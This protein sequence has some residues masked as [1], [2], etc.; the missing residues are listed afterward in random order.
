L[1]AQI[2]QQF[3]RYCIIRQLGAGA[4]GS[5]YLARDTQLDRDVALKVPQFKEGR[6]PQI[7]ARFYQEARAAATIHHPHVCPVY[8]VGEIDGIPYLTMAFIEG[9]PL[10]E[11]VSSGKP[12]NERQIATIGRKIAEALYEAHKKG[13]IHRDLKPANIMINRRGEPIVMDFGLAQR[14]RE[15]DTRLTRMGAI[16]GSPAYMSPEQVRGETDTTGPGTDV[17]SLGVILYELLARRLPFDGRSIGAVHAQ[18]LMD[19]PPSLFDLCP[20]ISPDFE[21]IC[22]KAL[23]KKAEERHKSMAHMAVA[24]KNFLSGSRE[25]SRSSPVVVHLASP[26]PPQ[27]QSPKATRSGMS[28]STIGG[29]SVVLAQHEEVKREEPKRKKKRKKEKRPKTSAWVAIVGIAAIL[30][31]ALAGIPIA[32]RMSSKSDSTES[33]NRKKPDETEGQSSGSNAVPVIPADFQSLFNGKD[34][35]GWIVD[36]GEESVWRVDRASGELRYEVGRGESKYRWLITDRNFSDYILRLDFQIDDKSDSG[37]SIRQLPRQLAPLEVQ[38]RNGPPKSTGKG[39]EPFI[40]GAL[41]QIALDNAPVILPRGRWNALE[42][43]VKGDL[44]GVKVNGKDTVMDASLSSPDVV[45]Y[46]NEA[47]PKTGRIGL[48]AFEGSGRFRNIAIKD[49]NPNKNS[50]GL[51]FRPLF[52][53]TDYKTDWEAGPGTPPGAWRIDNNSLVS[54][55]ADPTKPVPPTLLVT[56]KEFADYDLRFEFKTSAGGLSGVVPRTILGQEVQLGIPV[57][58]DSY[59]RFR[60]IPD[61][62]QTLFTGALRYVVI[63][64]QASL[65]P[66]EQWNSMIVRVRWPYIRVAVNGQDTVTMASM[67]S[68]KISKLLGKSLP[69]SGK[70]GLVNSL[71]IT[72]FRNIEIQEQTPR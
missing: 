64:K 31:A 38:L 61:P 51:E 70:I 37:V 26:P 71:G 20:D 41:N 6:E 8:D 5:V 10:E 43:T 56:R 14:A 9:K 45:K 53:G 67:E 65:N 33:S 63:D 17:F 66:I 42:I 44:V 39:Y 32:L 28:G 12:L 19:E 22:M 54:I 34:L 18:I 35:N 60:K 29:R 16:L 68:D 30:L 40:T 72:S 23:A 49:L 55:G 50:Q 2:P 21:A 69:R 3:G 4:M 58:H 59:P 27:S 24:I 25:T 13:V 36:S 46:V 62:T 1:T 48:Q 57:M 7:M 52:N 15:D 47:V 11:W